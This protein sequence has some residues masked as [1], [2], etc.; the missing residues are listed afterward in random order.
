MVFATEQASFVNTLPGK[1]S[2][3]SRRL[4]QAEARALYLDSEEYLVNPRISIRNF[5][6][7]R[8]L[9]GKYFIEVKK[10]FGAIEWEGWIK[11]Y[12]SEISVST[13][14]LW[15]D[16]YR[17]TSYHFVAHAPIDELKTLFIYLMYKAL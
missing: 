4:S 3:A 14:F 12:W 11:H 16:L 10:N 7:S 2:L 9:I 13:S 17:R 5:I 15:M 1:S 6:F 8:W